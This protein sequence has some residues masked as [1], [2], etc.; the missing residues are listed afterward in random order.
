MNRTRIEWTDRTWNPITGC[1]H[2]CAYCYARRIYQRF[3]RSFEPGFHMHRLYEPFRVK[4]PS[5][6]FLG[7][8]TDLNCDGVRREWVHAVADVCART[9]RH[10]YQVLSK[11]PD[12]WCA[13]DWPPNVWLGATA[14]DQSSWDRAEEALAPILAGRSGQHGAVPGHTLPRVRG[15]ARG[16]ADGDARPRDGHPE[17]DG[18]L[19]QH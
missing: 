10:T 19:E 15:R 16:A 2:G 18:V 17:R 4:R 7:S 12:R 1:T 3:G 5:R 11:R 6:I 13:E 8:V 9:P 14:T